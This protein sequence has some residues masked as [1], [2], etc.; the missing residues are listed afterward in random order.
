MLFV[1][2]ML[3]IVITVDSIIGSIEQKEYWILSARVTYLVVCI[4][5]MI[6]LIITK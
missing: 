5:C 4:F 2:L 1:A 6:M 3:M